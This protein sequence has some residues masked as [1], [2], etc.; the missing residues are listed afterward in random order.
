MTNGAVACSGWMI[1]PAAIFFEPVVTAND[2][3]PGVVDGKCNALAVKQADEIFRVQ[4]FN[5]L[6]RVA[7]PL[8]EI[9]AVFR[10]QRGNARLPVERRLRRM[11]TDWNSTAA[12]AA[13]GHRQGG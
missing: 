12:R 5:K 13:A 4:P 7:A 9:G 3:A 6:G 10:R 8:G 11:E 2:V 1:A